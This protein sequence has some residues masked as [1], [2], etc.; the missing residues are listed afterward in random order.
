MRR[1]AALRGYQKTAA[2]AVA[3]AVGESRLFLLDYLLRALRVLVLLAIWRTVLPRHGTVN[4]LSLGAVL[5]YTLIAEVFAEQLLARTEATSDLWSGGVTGRMVQP[6][7]LF[8]HYAAVMAG[9]WLVGLALFSLPLLVLAPL[10]GVDPRPAGFGAGLLFALSLAL[11][12]TLGLAIEFFFVGLTVA[13]ALNPWIVSRV[14]DGVALVLS[15][16]VVPLALLP[17]GLGAVFAWLPF[18]SMASAPLQIYV[19]AGQPLLLLALQVAWCLAL[20]PLV[21]W[22]WRANR[23]KVVGFGG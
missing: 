8:G 11:A 22:L 14:R 10:L 21:I 4:G 7:G 16:A 6:T 1:L 20:W 5:T 19:G 17:W 3:S 2:M 18:A 23:E 15:G 9:G 13:F 12:V